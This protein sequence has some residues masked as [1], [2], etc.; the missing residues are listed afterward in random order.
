MSVNRVRDLCGMCVVPGSCTPVPLP[1]DLRIRRP[2]DD[3]TEGD[4]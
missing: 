2:H 3:E 1:V 4:E